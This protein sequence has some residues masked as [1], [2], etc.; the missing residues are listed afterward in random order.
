MINQIKR[1]TV[2]LQRRCATRRC[3]YIVWGVLQIIMNRRQ[4][5]TLTGSIVVAGC[6]ERR[7]SNS[8]SPT[9]SDKALSSDN[10]A[11]GSANHLGDFV[12]W[13]DDD[14]THNLQITI[15]KDSKILFDVA[16]KL[17]PNES[18]EISNP[19]S[20]QG[21]YEIRASIDSQPQIQDEWKI[22]SCHNFEYIQFY[23]S[24]QEAVE[25]EIRTKK[26]T[27][28]PTPTCA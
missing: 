7:I 17:G 21:V 24:N 13:N 5:F 2:A 16:R 9:S 27:I 3:L 15:K 20:R 12:L 14:K 25:V 11:T 23:I 8:S 22:A 28:V 1:S 6:N 26:E 19:I 4:F 18:S 10:E